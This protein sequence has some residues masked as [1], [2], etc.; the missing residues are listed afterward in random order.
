M[1]LSPSAGAVVARPLPWEDNHSHSILGAKPPLRESVHTR[2]ILS[3]R[4]RNGTAPVPYIAR[5]L[6]SAHTSTR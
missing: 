5:G 2:S 4:P 1:Q 6:T 3:L